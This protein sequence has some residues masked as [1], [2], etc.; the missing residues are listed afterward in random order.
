MTTTTKTFDSYDF[1][2]IMNGLALFMKTQDEFRDYNF[3]GSGLRALLRVLAF[4]QQ[5]QALQNNMM[6]NQLML[7]TSTLDANISS[8][9]TLLGYQPESS[10]ASSISVTL[11]VIPNDPTNPTATL[12]IDTTSRF[13]ATVGNT[14]ITF[15]PDKEYTAN[16]DSVNQQYVFAV[17]LIQGQWV[18]NTF[19]CQTQNGVESY[20]IPNADI[21]TTTLSVAVKPSATSTDYTTFTPFATAYDLGPDSDVFFLRKN[22]DGLYEIEFGDGRIGANLTYGNVIIVTYLTTSGSAGNGISKLTPSTGIGGNYNITITVPDG[23]SSSSGSDPEDAA[24]IKKMAPRAYSASGA[25]VN[26]NDYVVYAKKFYG[27]NAV[28]NSWGGEN[29]NPPKAGYTMLCVK[30]QS[31]TTLSDL[32]KANLLAYLDQ[33]NVGSITPVIVDPEFIFL[34]L[35]TNV[36]YAPN[37]TILTQQALINK[38][39][40]YLQTYSA[41]TLELFNSEFDVSNLLE[42]VNAVDK[43]IQ[44]NFSTVQYERQFVPLLS[45]PSSY[46]FN[47]FRNLQAGSIVIDGFTVADVDFT[48]VTYNIVDDSNGILNLQKTLAGNTQI[49]TKN[50]GTV[51]YVNGVVALAQ[52]DPNSITNGSYLS[53]RA[54]PGSYDPSLTGV[55]DTILKINKVNITLEQQNV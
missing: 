30:P 10:K 43:S 32:E 55:Q 42:F 33:Y 38:V 15:T 8:L 54:N 16:Y 44:G 2:D 14:A 12:T 41:Q 18:S 35:T 51:D 31:G 19:T 27:G 13:F 53:L 34:N 1:D 28:V 20:V 9:A 39:T 4:N 22:R 37:R 21:D 11:T 3:D 46:S 23:V 7:D 29:N 52:F 36:K 26:D 25:A 49:M 6:F 5:Q 40:T 24:S 47:F 17:N 48:G 50:I 45:Y